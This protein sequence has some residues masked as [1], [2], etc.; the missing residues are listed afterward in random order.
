[1]VVGW[2]ISGEG[3]RGLLSLLKE[4][5]AGYP[6]VLPEVADS[7]RVVPGVDGWR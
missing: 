6:R 7:A 2:L 1:M 5:D 4:R 3:P